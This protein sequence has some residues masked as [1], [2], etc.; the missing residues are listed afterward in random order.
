MILS[1]EKLKQVE[2]ADDRAGQLQ[3]RLRRILI[4]QAQSQTLVTYKELAE[5]LG[6]Q[7]PHSIHQL[8]ILLEQL[9]AQDTQKGAP[10]LAALCV[11]RLRHKLPAP[12]F[13]ITANQLG[14]FTGDPEGEEARKFHE[15]E[16]ARVLAAYC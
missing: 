9:M 3:Q 11:G 10:L 15:R 14:L 16:L 8:T 4:E 2:P 7:P 5:R 12:G 13:F 1:D 6:I